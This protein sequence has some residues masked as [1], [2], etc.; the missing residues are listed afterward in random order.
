M[1]QAFPAA[2]SPADAATTRLRDQRYILDEEVSE[3]QDLVFLI[4]GINPMELLL[5]CFRVMYK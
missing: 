2:C 4:A 1:S 3:E 5:P